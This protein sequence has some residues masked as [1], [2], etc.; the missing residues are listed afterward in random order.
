VTLAELVKALDEI[1]PFELQEGWDNSGLLVGHP[2]REVET[3]VLSID[4]DKELVESAPEGSV[5][6]THHPLIFGKMN[7]LDFSTYPAIHLETMVKRNL[8]HVALHTNFDRTH[9]NRH[10]TET[11]LGFGNPECEG[12]FCKVETDV[13]FDDLLRDLTG[14]LG[15]DAPKAV[16]CHDR[17][18]SLAI[19][20]GSGASLLD[21][22]DA[23]CFL[24]GDIKYHD[25]MKA[26]A[27]GI[28]MID[29][30]HFESERHFAPLLAAELKNMPI[31]AIISDSK[32]PF[33][34]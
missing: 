16:R 8:S 7:K 29:I 4:I 11:I 1:S 23:D 22:V 14:K 12:F 6:I 31:T 30:A 32:N 13:A 21:F 15:L 2:D 3:A 9:L 34:S 33:T 19:T 24:T 10:V 18:R 17:V 28:S 25:A 5:I 26:K 27:L 20:T